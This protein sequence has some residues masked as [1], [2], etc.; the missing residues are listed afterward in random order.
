MFLSH[1][2]Y[3]QEVLY[4]YVQQ[5]VCFVRVMSDLDASGSSQKHLESFEMWCWSRM[6]KISLTDHVRN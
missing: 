6:E 4:I 3:H 1:F 2:A 5:M